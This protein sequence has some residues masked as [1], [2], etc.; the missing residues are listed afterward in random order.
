MQNISSLIAFVVAIKE[1]GLKSTV[2]HISAFRQNFKNLVANFFGI[3]TRCKIS[4][5][6]FLN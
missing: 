4:A 5:L 1:K 2:N 6:Y 3:N